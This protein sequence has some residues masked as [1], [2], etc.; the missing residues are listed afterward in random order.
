MTLN[1]IFHLGLPGKCLSL[2]GCV[3]RCSLK[4]KMKHIVQ[5]HT[6]LDKNTLQGIRT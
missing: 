1:Y 4:S 5:G 3:K 2:F 6:C